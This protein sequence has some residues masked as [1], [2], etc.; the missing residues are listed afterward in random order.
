MKR[1]VFENSGKETGKTRASM[2]AAIIFFYLLPILV[3]SAYSLGLMPANSSWSIF[4]IGLVAGLCGAGI[5][6]ILLCQ[7][8]SSLRDKLTSE[9]IVKKKIPEPPKPVAPEQNFQFE[10]LQTRQS[11]LMADIQ[12]KEDDLQRAHQDQE[13]CHYHMQQAIQELEVYKNST[14]EQFQQRDQLL[15]DYQLTIEA[16]KEMIEQQQQQIN[17]LESRE[18][19]LSYELKTLL[20]VTHLDQDEVETQFSPPYP[21]NFPEEITERV[22]HIPQHEIETQFSPPYPQGFPEEIQDR[23]VHITPPY[24]LSEPESE[25]VM[26]LEQTESI[27]VLTPETAS[28]ELKRCI[29]I[30]T[31]IT[32]ANAGGG[33]PRLIVDNYALDL[34][35][36]CDSLRNENSCIVLLFSQNENKLLFANNQ[37]KNMLGWTSE[38]FIQSFSE[39]IQDSTEEW[40]K[41]ISLLTTQPEARI[42]VEIGT[43]AGDTSPF[44]CHLASI[45]TGPFRH[46]IIAVLYPFK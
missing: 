22:A 44:Y 5:L 1:D 34:R 27:A 10:E 41:G 12:A 3:L 30:A 4:S 35:Q 39:I 29:E 8:E 2:A 33:N 23:V 32:G 37:V 26:P 25:S 21:Q 46:H 14:L 17:A 42:R 11:K 9:V 38:K 28:Q 15:K 13:Q 6:Y 19:D 18:K 40:R 7:W 43:K 24:P 36:L 31:R 45:P 20:Q 16:Q